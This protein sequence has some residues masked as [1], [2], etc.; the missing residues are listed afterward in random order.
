MT[1]QTKSKF[2]ALLALIT[3]GLLAVT[4]EIQAQAPPED[5]EN[6]AWITNTNGLTWKKEIRYFFRLGTK[7]ASLYF[8]ESDKPK[9]ASIL[10]PEHVEITAINVK[11]C[12]NLTNLVIQP[13]RAGYYAPAEVRGER[14]PHYF[15]TAL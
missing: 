15:G 6:F 1:T 3:A 5:P 13:P 4:P 11:G 9:I 8:D 12:V 14:I 2:L 7:G 10:V